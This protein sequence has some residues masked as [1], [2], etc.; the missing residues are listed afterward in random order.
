M[1]ATVQYSTNPMWITYF[2]ISCNNL[3][4]AEKKLKIHAVYIPVSYCLN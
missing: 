1:I 2:K 4:Y 3:I